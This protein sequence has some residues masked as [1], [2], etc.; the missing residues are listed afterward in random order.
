VPGFRDRQL[1]GRESVQDD[2]NLELDGAVAGLSVAAPGLPVPGMAPVSCA[3]VVDTALPRRH[4]AP[5]PVT[6]AREQQEPA[7]VR[8]KDASDG[9]GLRAEEPDLTRQRS[10]HQE[11]TTITGREPLSFRRKVTL[12]VEH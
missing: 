1:W 11:A 3:T 7:G 8:R 4:T 12:R 2:R 6:S 5:R 10:G 9:G